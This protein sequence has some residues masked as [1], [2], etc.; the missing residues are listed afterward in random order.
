[1]QKQLATLTKQI[2]ELEAAQKLAEEQNKAEV[3]KARAELEAALSSEKA[4]ANDLARQGKD[5]IQEIGSLRDHNQQLEAEMAKVARVGK[6]EELDF[7]EEAHSWPGIWVGEKLPRNGDFLMAFS[8]AAGNALKPIMVID[9]KEKASVTEA[10]VRKLVR[11]A[12]ERKLAVAALVTRDE[13]QLRHADRQSRWGQEDGVWLL[14]STRAWL[15]R[16]FEVL[17]P[18]FERMRAEG[19]DYL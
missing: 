7:V 2:A 3:A 6:R 9:N 12:R 5:Y 1:L 16:D 10:D 17:C 11:D 14:R 8:D 13:S 19:P 4:K 15:P 18:V